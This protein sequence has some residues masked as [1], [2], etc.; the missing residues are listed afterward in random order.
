MNSAGIS[1]HR[2]WKMH[3]THI[4]QLLACSRCVE[5]WPLTSQ[6]AE[7]H[8]GP[9]IKTHFNLL[10]CMAL[11]TRINKLHMH[12][13]VCGGE[14]ALNI[15]SHVTVSCT[16]LETLSQVFLSRKIELRLRE[17]VISSRAL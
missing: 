12:Q 15:Q 7:I 5:G 6:S 16:C 8:P 13:A 17:D 11:H 1:D 4:P 14:S 3:K 2:Q 9:L 10:G